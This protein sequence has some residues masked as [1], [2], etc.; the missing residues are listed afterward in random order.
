MNGKKQSGL[1]T[2]SGPPSVWPEKWFQKFFC[3]EPEPEACESCWAEWN[4]RHG[5][6]PDDDD[7]IPY[8][9]ENEEPPSYDPN[10]PI[11]VANWEVR[12]F[13]FRMSR[14]YWIQERQRKRQ[15]KQWPNKSL[16]RPMQE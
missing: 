14:D 5:Q 10:C 2:L 8:L 16:L 7:W 6:T 12:L 11:C 9:W 13:E 4:K 3:T 15:S 1:F